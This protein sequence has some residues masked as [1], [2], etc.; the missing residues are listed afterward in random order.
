MG[1]IDDVA[2][3]MGLQAPAAPPPETGPSSFNPVKA[4]PY[5]MKRNI[6]QASGMLGEAGRSWEEGRYG[7]AGFYG[8][9]GALSGAMSPVTSAFQLATGP[10]AY[11]TGIPEEA[12]TTMAMLGGGGGAALRGGG[13]LLG[14]VGGMFPG[15]AR[16]AEEAPAYTALPRSG[17][18]P[19][20]IEGP[21]PWDP[22]GPSYGP[23][24]MGSRPGP[25]VYERYAEGYQPRFGVEEPPAMAT[26]A[27][28]PG[29]ALPA[30]RVLD[31]EPT[32]PPMGPEGQI[33]YRQ[34]IR[35][36]FMMPGQ[37]Q[38]RR[39]QPPQ[40][41]WLMPDLS[42][43]PRIPG[44]IPGEY[45]NWGPVQPPLLQDM[46]PG[47]TPPARLPAGVMPQARGRWW[48][49]QRGAIQQNE[50]AIAAKEASRARAQEPSDVELWHGEAKAQAQKYSSIDNLLGPRREP[51]AAPAGPA[52]GTNVP[53]RKTIDPFTE[54]KENGRFMKDLRKAIQDADKAFKAGDRSD[55]IASLRGVNAERNQIAAATAK[56]RHVTA[57]IEQIGARAGVQK[58]IQAVAE[59]AG[60]SDME[61]LHYFTLAEKLDYI[62]PRATSGH[63]GYYELTPF[64]TKVREQRVAQ[65]QKVQSMIDKAERKTE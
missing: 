27:Q 7:R 11:Y 39:P 29:G 19:K 64:W 30:P 61:A 24:P 3:E 58:I 18:G 21:L 50:S 48:Q 60:V 26:P 33:G 5:W 52:P 22:E 59:R 16:M 10:A 51:P 45:R 9:L 41:A 44:A 2:G 62:R 37:P 65:R 56:A 20:M 17:P 42:G 12:L 23:I 53:K 32:P 34:P 28:G 14:M 38:W 15:A 46:R 31:I 55:A 36:E 63:M 40:G 8:G 6:E 1:I 13:K 47:W 43:E 25:S 35:E 57:A 54:V 49:S 4:Y